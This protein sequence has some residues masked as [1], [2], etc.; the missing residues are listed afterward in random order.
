MHPLTQPFAALA[1]G[2]L[3]LA[4]LPA[5]AS[6]FKLANKPGERIVRHSMVVE[7][8]YMQPIV[9]ENGREN[10]PREQSDAYFYAHLK[11]ASAN[12]HGFSKF[13][14]I[15]YLNVSY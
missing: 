1:A 14:W 12:P 5:A 8:G 13:A 3:A 9:L 10:R 15:P 6:E 2:L 7:G 4:V 11:A